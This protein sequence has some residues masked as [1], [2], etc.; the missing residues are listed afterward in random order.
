[1]IEVRRHIT[2]GGREPFS[3]W[4]DSLDPSARGKIQAVLERMGR[5]VLSDVKSLGGGLFECRVNFGPG[6]RIY[7]ARVG[8]RV[9][10]LLG[11]GAKGSQGR[12]IRR[13]R[14]FL[15]EYV[16]GI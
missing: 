10:V 7:F 3:Q 8:R 15:R 13:A 2:I 1:M 6:Y 9:I 4:L 16:R 14:R 5:G 12:D 11:G